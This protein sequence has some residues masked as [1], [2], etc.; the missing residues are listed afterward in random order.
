MTVLMLVTTAYLAVVPI[1]GRRSYR[2]LLAASGS[3]PTATTTF[4]RRNVA[5][6]WVLAAPVV[7]CLIIWPGLGP[8]H[9]GL[10]WPHGYVVALGT[11]FV[12]ILGVALGL[13][14]VL[15]RR[16]VRSG[17][18]VYGLRRVRALVP[19]RSGW[20]WAFA[21]LI[22]ASIVEELVYR[23]LLI[24]VGR[25]LGLSVT[26]ALVLTSVLFGLAHLYQGPAGMVGTGVLGFTLGYWL[27]A[28]GSLLL[29]IVLHLLVNI[30]ALAVFRIV[31]P[32]TAELATAPT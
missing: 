29:A 32:V 14:V 31:A 28:T 19:D 15:L 21:A 7:L 4:Y 3:D 13:S 9:L 5:L 22:S 30:R 24:A 11:W 2:R 26:V 16:R 1:R 17:R 8:A 10:A 20:R 12:A 25:A 18:P 6:K 23:G 27:L